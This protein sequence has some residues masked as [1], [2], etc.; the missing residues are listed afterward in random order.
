[1]ITYGTLTRED[2]RELSGI[3][4]SD[5]SKSWCAVSNGELVEEDREFR[6]VGFSEEQWN[7]IAREFGEAL[8][9]GSMVFAGAWS[10]GRLV[11]VAGLDLSRRFGPKGNLL[12]LGPMWV[13]RESR[14]LGIGRRLFD[15]LLD[16]AAGHDIDGLYVSATPTPATVAFYMAMGCRLLP[17][18]DSELYRRE[19]EDIHMYVPLS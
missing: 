16:R 7:G 10:E 5:Y 17:R 4:R 6:H 9:R 15:M 12:N 18:P 13:S 11:G 3:D 8:D 1:M 14:G 19:P 2:L